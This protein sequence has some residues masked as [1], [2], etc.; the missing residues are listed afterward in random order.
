MSY[1]RISHTKA[2]SHLA[3]QNSQGLLHY[4][5]QHK[6]IQLDTLANESLQVT[7]QQQVKLCL[8]QGYQSTTMKH[9]PQQTCF[10]N[11]NLRSHQVQLSYPTR[12]GQIA[13]R[14]GRAMLTSCW[15]SP[16]RGVAGT[17]HS[18]PFFRVPTQV[19]TSPPGRSRLSSFS[20]LPQYHP[21][22]VH[23]LFRAH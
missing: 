14:A 10:Y 16:E 5:R 3:G 4:K 15:V 7:M 13:A 11:P 22:S 18:H 1:K 2:W 21:I 17:S 12:M 23:K 6:V 19:C 9:T 8:P 20:D